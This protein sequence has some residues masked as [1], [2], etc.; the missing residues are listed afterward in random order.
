MGQMPEFVIDLYN[1]LQ[2]LA[3]RTQLLAQRALFLGKRTAL[4][5][6]WTEY[7]DAYGCFVDQI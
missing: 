3:A 2:Q 6:S 1:T 5:A 4:T 7:N